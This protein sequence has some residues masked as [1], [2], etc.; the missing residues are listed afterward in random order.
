MK[1]KT[2]NKSLC[3]KILLIL[4]LI[5]FILILTVSISKSDI[6][7]LKAKKIGYTDFISKIE[8]GEIK[9]VREKDEYI[10]G[11]TEGKKTADYKAEKI[12]GRVGD[13]PDLLQI[14]ESKNVTLKIQQ[15]TGPNYIIP[16]LINIFVIVSIIGIPII[17]LIA[18]GIFVYLLIS[19]SEK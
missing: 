10:F 5:L 16:L 1:K 3:K 18:I 12:T 19:K 9:E 8:D 14:I 6:S 17:S 11:T 2:K 7:E 15:P 4:G 13:D